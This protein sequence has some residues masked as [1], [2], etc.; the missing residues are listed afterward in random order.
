MLVSHC[1]VQSRQQQRENNADERIQKCDYTPSQ[2]ACATSKINLQFKHACLYGRKQNEGGGGGVPYGEMNPP[3]PCLQAR[4]SA[5]C[6]ILSHRTSPSLCISLCISMLQKLFLHTPPKILPR[7]H[8]HS[9]GTSQKALFG[10]FFGMHFSTSF[11]DFIFL[12]FWSQ[13]GGKTGP[14]IALF[15]PKIVKNASRSKKADFHELLRIRTTKPTFPTSKGL[16][17]STFALPTATFGVSE[18]HLRFGIAFSSKKC[19]K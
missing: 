15:P 3:P 4:R 17:K 9:A 13:N 19:P 16:H 12:T 11:L 7:S 2:R 18:I 5:A 1:R 14:R 8:C 6:Q 10:D